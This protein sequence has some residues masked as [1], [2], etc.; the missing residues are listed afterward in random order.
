M[1]LNTWLNSWFIGIVV[2]C[3]I[4]SAPIGLVF[5]SLA[6]P[7][8]EVWQHLYQTVLSDYVINSLLLAFGVGGLVVLIGT[9]LAWFIARYDFIG[10]RQ[11]QWIV[12]LPMAIPAYIIAYSY[13]GLLD[14]S[15]PFQS[16]LRVIFDWQ[17][18]DYYFPEVRSL[19]GA[20]IMLSL[21]L[22]PYVYMLAKTAFSELPVSLEEVSK[23]LG[24]SSN[25]YIFKVVLPL[26][27]PAILMGA[28]LAM[29]EAFADYGT[30]QYF[31][32]STFTT[33]IFR[34]W[35][36]L[37]NGL[38]AAQLAALLTSFV[39]M[40]LILEY[41]SRRKIQYYFQGQK[42]KS[43]KRQVLTGYR[44]YFVAF[45]CLLPVIL[46]FIVP[47]AQLVVWALDSF[48]EQFDQR[49]L[50]LIWNSFYLAFITSISAV[51]LAL[52]F[53]YGKRLNRFKP[54]HTVV[55]FVSLG[56]AL[57]GTVIAIGVLLILSWL[58]IKINGVTE[59]WFDVSVGLI[60][61]GTL[62]ALVLAYCIRFLAVAMHNIDTGMAR[63]K[64][65]IDD[66]AKS[67]GQSPL[68]ILKRIHLP[69]LKTSVFSA[70]L[71]VF[72]D[73]L[74]ELPATLILRPFNFNTLAVKTF[75][76]ASDERLMEAALPA[77]AIVLVGIIPVVL[78]TRM[79]DSNEK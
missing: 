26:A 2:C 65:S 69:L 74:K 47:I 17:Y 73:V 55:N 7:Q 1:R 30:V 71:L 33:G 53:A 43:C 64:P 50:T 27:R 68:N 58:D 11:I 20:I 48:A 16:Y 22:Y 19:G 25:K 44:S 52:L 78:L 46:G 62:F 10:R 61:S 13:T 32:I 57:P 3:A 60:L 24:L 76:I 59:A 51:T 45:L 70:L 77:L 23:S 75:E 8:T 72:V 40:L 15:G 36:G 4:L 34:T 35:F 12:L 29:M 66:A 79:T 39:V 21:V 56:Y 41:L 9:P 18:G 14:F 31:G 67:L 42:A 6:F 63:I 5:A 49:F 28:A 38:A 54:L 37:A